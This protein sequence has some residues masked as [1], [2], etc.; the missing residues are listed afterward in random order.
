MVM[1]VLWG[2]ISP[3]LL[4]LHGLIRQP[5]VAAVRVA[6]QLPV[7]YRAVA[8]AGEQLVVVVRVNAQAGAAALHPAHR[9]VRPVTLAVRGLAG[10][11]VGRML[12]HC[13]VRATAALRGTVLPLL[14]DPVPHR[15]ASVGCALS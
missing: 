6:A 5:P 1:M 4:Q 9:V 13:L 7:P 11:A 12:G 15:D 8:A 2:H 14:F 10:G 3:Q